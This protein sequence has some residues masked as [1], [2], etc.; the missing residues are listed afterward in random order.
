M[1][2]VVCMVVEGVHSRGMIR[3]IVGATLPFF[4]DPGTIRGDF[5]VDA[6]TAANTQNRSI[7]NL[8]HASETEE[9]A[10][11]E[12]DHW[13]SPEDL[14]EYYRTDDSIAYG[15]RRSEDFTKKK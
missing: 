14:H 12:I 15:D 13:F 1:G 4:A 2:P 5:S 11:N 10:T 3:K 9:E 6:S 7:F 8:I